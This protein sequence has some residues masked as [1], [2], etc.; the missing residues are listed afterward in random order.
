MFSP[1]SPS[2]LGTA[3]CY[4]NKGTA[5]SLINSLYEY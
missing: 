4:L 2:R 3:D 1:I 5:M